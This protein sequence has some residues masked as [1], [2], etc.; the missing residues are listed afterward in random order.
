MWFHIH[1]WCWSYKSLG[2]GQSH[3]ITSPYLTKI[4]NNAY[5][6]VKHEASSMHNSINL[7][8]LFHYL[9]LRPCLPAVGWTGR[10]SWFTFQLVALT[11]LAGRQEEHPAS[12]NCMM[13]CWCGHLEQGA[14]GL[15]TVQLMP[16]HPKTSSSLASYKSRL[17][18]PLWYRLTQVVLEKA[19]NWVY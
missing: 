19:I 14:D 4:R 7:S 11:L 5:L 6:S 13:R 18:L 3:I 2:Q 9:L 1:Q 8:P 15:H 16:L 10:C 17:V 12:K